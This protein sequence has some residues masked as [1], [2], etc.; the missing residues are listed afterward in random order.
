MDHY[1]VLLKKQIN[2]TFGGRN[3]CD[4]FSE[5]IQRLLEVINNTYLEF[6][7]DK[8]LLERSI[9][10]SSREYNESVEKIYKLQSQLIHQEK[11][12]GIGQLSAGIAHEI[13][14]PLGFIQSNIET[15]IKYLTRIESL[16]QL[17]KKLINTDNELSID[18]YNQ[19]IDEIRSYFKKN[20]IDYIFNDLKEIT[21]ESMNGLQRIEK[22]VKSLLGFSRKGYENDFNDYDLNQGIK[23]TLV[24]ANNEIKY[25]ANVVSELETIPVIYASY[26]EIN[27]VALNLIINAAHAIRDK[28]INGTIK[29][30]TY[31]DENHVY[32]EI[33]DDG[34]GIKE[35]NINRIF[36]PFFTTKPI[37]TGTG[38]G[39]S[40]AHDIIVNKHCGK[41]DVSSKVGIGSTFKITLP[42]TK[43]NEND[44]TGDD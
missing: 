16:Y 13:N 15:L 9:D 39:L 34:A 1:H 2:K 38:L 5:E 11:M 30:H 24:I 19:K 37:G 42:I 41:I 7:N 25:Y 31:A 40:I 36:E 22:I 20:K 33:T 32:C 43:K 4:M 6:E 23:D 44:E 27:Q 14:N 35:T 12:A 29:I 8:A 10:I 17:N 26:G 18:Q 21:D 28:G 3:S